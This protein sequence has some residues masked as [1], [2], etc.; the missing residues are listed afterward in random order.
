M[1]DDRLFEVL[2]KQSRRYFTH[3]LKNYQAKDVA[4]HEKKG[5]SKISLVLEGPIYNILEI[6]GK[7]FKCDSPLEKQLEANNSLKFIEVKVQCKNCL[8]NNYFDLTAH[9][10]TA[11]HFV[12][13][14]KKLSKAK[15]IL[16]LGRGDN[17]HDL[18]FYD[19]IGLDL[20]KVIGVI[21]ERSEED[22]LA[23]IEEHSNLE[24]CLFFHLPRYRP[25]RIKDLD[26]DVALVTDLI[27]EVLHGFYPTELQESLLWFRPESGPLSAPVNA[28]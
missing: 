24:K 18:I 26:F 11:G 20:D 10:S 1:P 28:G 23:G 5:G 6:T 12:E 4:I 8:A 22:E 3:L 13:L 9:E 19:V 14:K 17:A 15:K 27:P 16:I 25:N 2:V 21:D 7:C